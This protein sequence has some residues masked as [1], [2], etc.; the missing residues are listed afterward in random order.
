MFAVSEIPAKRCTDPARVTTK[1][2]PITVQ[3]RLNRCHRGP[4]RLE[5][6]RHALLRE[7][8]KSQCGI[9]DRDPVPTSGNLAV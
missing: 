9:A 3:L 1:R 2:E 8:I 4:A 5:R 7:R 6:P